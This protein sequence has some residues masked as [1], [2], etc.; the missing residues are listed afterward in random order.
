MPV[1]ANGMK[2]QIRIQHFITLELVTI[3]P[4]KSS[5]VCRGNLRK[6]SANRINTGFLLANKAFDPFRQAE[7]HI[8]G[9]Q[10]AQPG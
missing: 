8:Q 7:F 5:Q 9:V 10:T 3:A 2:R 1:Y 4:V 6:D